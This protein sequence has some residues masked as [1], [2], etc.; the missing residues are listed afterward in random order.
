MAIELAIF[1]IRYSHHRVPAVRTPL[2][3]RRLS[4]Y[5]LPPRGNRQSFAICICEHFNCVTEIIMP[6]SYAE[7]L[8]LR[9]RLRFSMQIQSTRFPS[10]F[11]RSKNPENNAKNLRK[12]QIEEAPKQC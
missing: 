12:M 8:R 4:F 10:P 5:T 11:R 1:A 2:S 9:L 6:T 3:H 7:R